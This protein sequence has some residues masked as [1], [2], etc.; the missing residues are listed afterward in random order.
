[1][2]GCL[3]LEWAH[4]PL[5]IDNPSYSESEF[6]V[7]KRELI[8]DS[9]ANIKVS[10]GEDYDSVKDGIRRLVDT[11]GWEL[12]NGDEIRKTFHCRNWTKIMVRCENRMIEGSRIR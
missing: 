12:L 3:F 2:H 4:T 1:M 7:P 11:S 9:L 6:F 5:L 10:D 8:M